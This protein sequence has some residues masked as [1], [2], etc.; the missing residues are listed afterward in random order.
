MPQVRVSVAVP[1]SAADV[2]EFLADGCNLARWHSGVA[3]IRA[4]RA[5][6]YRYRFP[7]RRRETLLQR[8]LDHEGRRISFLGGGSG[9]P[10]AARCRATTSGWRPMVTA[11][12]STSASACA[13]G[14]G[15]VALWPV[16]EMGW[17][18]DL[19]EDARRLY[20]LLTVGQ[21]GAVADGGTARARSP[22]G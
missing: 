10:S 4:D 5:G 16:V 1:R 9:P 20:R 18:R 7:G 12:M 19:P 15:M 22:Q 6:S 2:F 11:A 8:W 14:A 13:C 17:R 3:E 21:G